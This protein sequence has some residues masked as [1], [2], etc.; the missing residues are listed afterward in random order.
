VSDGS[1]SK[2]S[3]QRAAGITRKLHET[4]LKTPGVTHVELV[5]D[6]GDSAVWGV[7]CDEVP[8]SITWSIT[9]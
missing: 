4:L 5:V 7:I 9:P 8:C 3:L 6:D 1:S 2:E